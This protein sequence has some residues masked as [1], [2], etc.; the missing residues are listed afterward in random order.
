M[1][2]NEGELSKL[3]DEARETLRANLINHLKPLL[4]QLSKNGESNMSAIFGILKD[5]VNNIPNIAD[6]S[7]SLITDNVREIVTDVIR[8]ENVKK[9]IKKSASKFMSVVPDE[10]ESHKFDVPRSKIKPGER[11]DNLESLDDD[12]ENFNDDEIN[13]PD[14]NL[15]WPLPDTNNNI[16]ADSI[17]DKIRK[18]AD[19]IRRRWH[20]TFRGARIRAIQQ[21][22]DG[23]DDPDDLW[24]QIYLPGA[25]R[26][27]NLNHKKLIA[28][29]IA[30][31]ASI[32]TANEI[33]KSIRSGNTIKIEP[34]IIDKK[35]DK[36]NIPDTITPIEKP[37]MTFPERTKIIDAVNAL[38]ADQRGPME[39]LLH[40]SEVQKI[41]EATPEAKDAP[42]KPKIIVRSVSELTPDSDE[43]GI[44][45]KPEYAQYE[46]QINEYNAEYEKYKNNFTKNNLTA[47]E[48]ITQD[49]NQKRLKIMSL[50][51]QGIEDTGI[52]NKPREI[53]ARI[54]LEKARKVYVDSQRE[55]DSNYKAL[56]DAI[57]SGASRHV[58][59]NLYIKL[60]DNRARLKKAKL[61]HV[62]NM[63]VDRYISSVNTRSFL[64]TDEIFP[65]DNPDEIAAFK[66]IQNLESHMD[67][68][69]DGNDAGDIYK[70]IMSQHVD[71][72]NY[73]SNLAYYN[74]REAV[75]K[76]LYGK[77]G[78]TLPDIKDDK[79][80]N[81]EDDPNTFVNL[82]DYDAT[83]DQEEGLARAE[84]VDPAEYELFLSQ[85]QS[86]QEQRKLF[87][88]YSVVHPGHGLGTVQSNPVMR[89]AIRQDLKRFTNNYKSNH[90]YMVPTMHQQ[91]MNAPQATQ[92]LFVPVYQ[93][94]YGH[95]QMEDAY[96][97]AYKGLTPV[98]M[99]S[100]NIREFEN[101]RSV[102]F[103][104]HQL[105]TYTPSP[106][107]IQELRPTY[108]FGMP[109]S[110]K[111]SQNNN[112][113]YKDKHTGYNFDGGTMRNDNFDDKPTKTRMNS[114]LN[115]R[116]V[117]SSRMR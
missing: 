95:V 15:D 69:I 105:S 106:T 46:A 63:N 35:N 76:D 67:G 110:Y 58:I 80:A 57:N 77:I 81:K 62:Y 4:L 78:Q 20:N 43:P 64:T 53:E 22:D 60:E 88:Q 12:F 72:A 42:T 74:Q 38:P 44:V 73:P 89:H 79:F 82:T 30:L 90:P 101:N 47:P 66:R 59:E 17:I 50:V 96:H 117:R 10:K 1:E 55:F 25:N 34:S 40:D 104:E 75:L 70:N 51:N 109:K 112:V 19:D 14:E 8:G 7:R 102:L 52:I 21:P 113:L 98:Y 54:S 33:V 92:P 36:K 115:H 28:L 83:Q 26:Y 56:Q 37:T 31:G 108:G 48:S 91:E 85:K 11:P 6:V 45:M 99:R 39:Q 111:P 23:G 93:N 114:S 71:R 116:N 29:L 18:S 9:S 41:V 3:R 13:F 87:D 5:I 65:D 32:V 97:N 84:V 94:E 24:T 49:M 16:F 61:D 2:G 103:P 86:A 68:Q 27:I 107:K 100:N